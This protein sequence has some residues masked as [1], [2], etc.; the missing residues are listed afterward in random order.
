MRLRKFKVGP[1]TQILGVEKEAFLGPPLRVG[2]FC[3]LM[4]LA[5]AKAS[6]FAH[7]SPPRATPPLE[8]PPRTDSARFHNVVYWEG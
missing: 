1:A 7:F 5:H 3:H 8:G 6:Q 2:P 4:Y